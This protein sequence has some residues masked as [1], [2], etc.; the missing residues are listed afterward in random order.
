MSKYS[1]NTSLLD[2]LFNM[3]LAFVALFVIAFVLARKEDRKQD[4]NVKILGEITVT[5]TWDSGRN[6]D[7]DLWMRDPEGNI[8]FFRRPQAGLMH[9]D[10][11]DIGF[12]SD[13]VQTE[14]GTGTS[15]GNQEIITVRAIVPGEYVINVHAF[16]I[17]EGRPIDVSVR[18][19]RLSPSSTI[20]AKTVTLDDTG[21]EKTVV[22]LRFGDDKKILAFS[23]LQC[24]LIRS[25]ESE[26][27]R[28]EHGDYNQRGP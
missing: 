8:V 6:D 12:Q 20:V 15:I 19:D 18:I 3:L 27:R 4:K 5:L 11:D 16:Q 2:V 9:L 28:N 10:R 22:R 13:T 17:R 23:D 26:D 25:A 21:H 1:C 7:I 24:D 14:V